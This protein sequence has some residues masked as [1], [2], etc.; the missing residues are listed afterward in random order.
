MHQHIDIDYIVR[1]YRAY[2]HHLDRVREKQRELLVPPT[3][4]RAQLD[5]IEA[6]VT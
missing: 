6:E 1:L 4:L 2:A 5:D 3:S